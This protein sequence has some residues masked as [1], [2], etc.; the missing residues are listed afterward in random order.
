MTVCTANSIVVRPER[1]YYTE[2]QTVKDALLSSEHEFAGLAERNYLDSIDGVV[3]NYVYF[4]DNGGYNMDMPAS[5]ITAMHIGVNSVPAVNQE[6][7]LSVIK[8]MADYTA[9]ENNVQNYPAAQN[10]YK[11]C[12]TAIRG[13][14]SAASSAK[15]TLDSAVAEYEAILNGP[16]YTVTVTATQGGES[17]ANPVITM[18]DAYGNVSSALGHSIS[19]IAG[20]YT[21]S[22][23]DGGYNRTEGSIKVRKNISFSV[24]L[25]TGEWF[26]E[27]YMRSY[28]WLT[29]YHEPYRCEQDET[30]HKT[31][32]LV[33]DTAEGYYGTNL[34]VY[35]GDVPDEETTLLRTIYLSED[36]RDFSE[37]QRNWAK[38][39]ATTTYGNFLDSLV[40]SGLEG[41][42][43]QIEGRYTL[44][45]G[46][47]QIQSYEI[48]IIRVPTL[49]DMTLEAD[50]CEI[51]LGNEIYHTSAFGE[52]ELYAIAFD[53]GTWEYNVTTVSDTLDINVIPF[54]ETYIVEGAGTITVDAGTTDHEVRVIAPNGCVGTYTLHITKM[55]AAPVTIHMPE[56]VSSEVKNSIGSVFSPLNGVYYLV[57]GEEYTC[58]LTK[59]TYYHVKKS[60]TASNGLAVEMPEPVTEDWLADLGIYCRSASGLQPSGNYGNIWIPHDCD[61][62]FISEKHQ[63]TYYISDCDTRFYMQATAVRGTPYACYTKVDDRYMEE[64]PYEVSNDQGALVPRRFLGVGGDQRIMTVRI[65]SSE[66]G[67]EFYQDYELYV[68]RIL[69]IKELTAYENGEEL[70]FIN[71]EG[72]A[73]EF[74]RDILSYTVIVNRDAEKITLKGSF[75]Y[76]GENNESNQR[77]YVL[78]NG[79]RYDYIGAND[80]GGIEYTL[81]PELKSETI[82]LQVSHPD[83]TAIET[84]YTIEVLKTEPVGVTVNADPE[85]LVLVLTSDLNGKRIFDENGVYWLTPGGSY[86]YT[87]TLAG[88]V[89]IS[90]KYTVP[91]QGGVL[92][93]HLDTAAANSSLINLSALWP[94][95]RQDND[96]NGVVNYPIPATADETVLYW[97]TKIGDGTDTSACSPPILV[98]GCLYLYAGTSLM[99]VDTMTGAIVASAAMDRSSSFGINPPTYAEGMI[100][101]GLANGTIQAFNAATLESLWIY[102]DPLGGQPNCSIVYNDGYIY[103]GFWNG[104][105]REANYVCLSVTDE[106]PAQAKEE[107]LVTWRYTTEGGFYWAGAY[108]CDSFVLVGT[109]DGHA[110]YTVGKAKLLSLDTKTGKPKSITQMTVPGDIR[111]S[112]THYNGKYYFTGKG[113]YFFEASVDAA[114]NIE[115]VRNLK[116][117]NYEDS[118]SNPPMSTSTPVIYN[119][120]AYIGVGGTGQF[121]AFS[122]HN[123][124][125]IDL[126]NWE[127]AYTVKTR[128]YP[129]ASGVLTTA[130]EQETGSVYVYFV[131]NYTPGIIRMLADRPGQTEPTVVT[132]EYIY[133]AAYNLFQ[134]TGAQAEY[135]I[136]SPIVDTDG[137]LYFKNDSGY[138]MA[139][140]STIE[141]LEV[142]QNPDKMNYQAGEL[143][144]STGL[145]VTAHYTNG[146][147]RDVTQYLTWSEDPLTAEDTDFQLEYPLVMYQNAQQ[148]NGSMLAGVEYTH[149]IATLNLSIEAESTVKYGDVN[150]DG[151]INMW[152]YR[153]IIQYYNDEI[154]FTP[155]EFKAADVDGN[156]RINMWDYRYIIQYYND[157]ISHF[158]V[159]QQS[160]P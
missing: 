73:E 100:F 152:D 93:V 87:A 90:G 99:K 69:C 123:I 138:L 16:R 58:T 122:G 65:S 61:S 125:V 34:V 91:E 60:F 18:T 32:V 41:R 50:G 48:E 81:A 84:T 30:I 126:G 151:K 117:Y 111:S 56:G 37:T 134:P 12:L 68:H 40:S 71:A 5:N 49:K 153:L 121:T 124:T 104:E 20:D 59:D 70:T 53:S 51:S 24:E 36:G 22:V 127:I 92:T 64:I 86:S 76:E 147:S 17:I 63:Y 102:H 143:F 132:A 113:G 85:N 94:H 130:Y 109:D 78:V 150:K 6:A 148:E 95:L 135:S 146:T 128:G 114:G 119:G 131:D 97:A 33:D 105:D 38:Q 96:N 55:D 101:V 140:G 158:P 2:G 66:D 106:D 47:V 1:V 13:D 155:D 46:L 10:A 29:G 21:F 42:N 39:G 160:S 45:N 72:E 8:T 107:K 89:G 136:C 25:P 11:A 141:S 19:V 108:V 156:G 4:Y 118:S 139:L 14:G 54:D 144:D 57:P 77:T 23:S 7:M 112:I 116:L 75:A 79:E 43:F 137:T 142:V 154:S 83:P 28:Y 74:D 26:G 3:A 98:D 35:I 62:D 52:T 110:S 80:I 67:V 115:T 82:T 27:M 31:T 159:E 88:Y 129:Q 103:T 44:E 15:E 149:P 133:T 145:K 120:R 157:E 9:Y